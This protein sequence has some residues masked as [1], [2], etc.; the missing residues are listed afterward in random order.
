M[1]SSVS[2]LAIVSLFVGVASGSLA[3]WQDG[4]LSVRQLSVGDMSFADRALGDKF[5]R[6]HAAAEKMAKQGWDHKP[7]ET[8]ADRRLDGVAYAHWCT[9]VE[10]DRL[11][12][13][14]YGGPRELN[15][16]Q[17]GAFF[18]PNPENPNAHKNINGA[19]VYAKWKPA[20][21]GWSAY[22]SYGKTTRIRDVFDCSFYYFAG[23]KEK[24][25]RLPLIESFL[26]GH[27]NYSGMFLFGEAGKQTQYSYLVTSWEKPRQVVLD[28]EVRRILK[29]PESLRDFLLVPYKNLLK[30]LHQD[31]PEEKGYSAK[32]Y[33]T[34]AVSDRRLSDAERKQVL[35]SACDEVE[36]KI[37]TVQNHYKA[38]FAAQRKAFPLRECLGE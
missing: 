30:R 2:V 10:Q 12:P 22:V 6:F 23:P 32:V 18:D 21:A 14:N 13:I 38:L 3:A 20:D 36:F 35:Q 33:P 28:D 37:R 9:F 27:A 1:R 31:I 4:Q 11:V 24:P 17:I 34:P 29:S 5:R 7:Y 26:D 15:T 16:V 25:G 8:F 19:F